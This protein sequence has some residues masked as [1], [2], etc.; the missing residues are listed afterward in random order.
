MEEIEMASRINELIKEDRT[1]KKL[2]RIETKMENDR[3][4]QFLLTAYQRA[5][6]EY[7]KAIEDKQDK[8]EPQKRLARLKFEVDTHP[9][10]AKYNKQYKKVNLLLEQIK[11]KLME[12]ID[13]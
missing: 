11:N 4:L 6:E 10:V 7:N 8:S 2:K 13:L 5:Q 1:Y 9:L 3:N 12:G